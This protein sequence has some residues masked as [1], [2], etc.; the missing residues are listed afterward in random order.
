MAVPQNVKFLSHHELTTFTATN[1]V[2]IANRSIQSIDVGDQE[3]RKKQEDPID[4]FEIGS[5]NLNATDTRAALPE[6]IDVIHGS[7][8]IV[9]VL[10]GGNNGDFSD[11]RH[12]QN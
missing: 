6:E 1:L 8:F 3:N 9:G 11:R 4:R 5:D 2:C 7:G 10:L 12:C